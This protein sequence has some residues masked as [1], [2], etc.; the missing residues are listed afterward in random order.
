MNTYKFWDT[1][2]IYICNKCDISEEYVMKST[3][4]ILYKM[5]YDFLQ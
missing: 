1:L 4:L 3:Y 5:S 2:N